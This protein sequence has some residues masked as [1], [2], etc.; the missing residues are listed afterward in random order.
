[1]KKISLVILFSFFAVISAFS[2][3]QMKANTGI[4]A[5]KMVDDQGTA[6]QYVN[7]LLHRQSDSTVIDAMATNDQGS[8]FFKDVNYGTYFLEFKFLGFK[9]KL[10]YDIS[11][12]KQ[13][14]FVRIGRV[15]LNADDQELSKVVVRGQASNVV[16]KIDKKIINVSKDIVA[17]GGDATDALRNVPSVNVGVN[18]DVTIRGSSNFTVMIN[19]KP[20]IL[21]PNE[22]LKSIPVENIDRIELITNPSAKYDP[23][24][25]A[26][27]INIITKNKKNDGFN[28]K[29]EIGTDNNLGYKGDIL[30][31]YK[32]NKINF[33]TEFNI[34]KRI[35]PMKYVSYRESFLPTDTFYMQ[36]NGENEWGHIG[37]E[38]KI[39]LNYYINDKTTLTL[40]GSYGVHGFIANSSS[41]QHAW[42]SDKSK[43]ENYFSS[44]ANNK[45]S[46]YTSNAEIDIE[47]KFNDKGHKIK[48]YAQYS[49]FTPVSN[50]ISIMDT[51]DAN[52]NSI[53]NTPFMQLTSQNRARTRARFQVDY[54]LPIGTKSKFQAGYTF[55][56]LEADGGY[57][58]ANFDYSTNNW[59]FDTTKYNDMTMYRQIHAAY[60]TFSSSLGKIFD[61]ELGFRTEYT[62]RLI[63]EDA[64]NTRYPIKRPDF[65]PTVHIS[66]SLPFDQQ[67]QL[68]YS[69][70]INRPRGWNLNPFPMYIDQYTIR[71][72]N[73]ALKPE[74]SNSYELNYLK[75]MGRNSISLETFYKTTEGKIDRI[76][77]IDG[78]AIVYT[79]ENLNKD[80]SLGSELSG[81]FIIFKMLML[82]ISS[83]AFNYRITGT[84]D[85]NPVDTSTF[86]W[87]SRINIMTMLPTGTGI[88]FGA[89]YKAPSVTLQ[90][91][92]SSMF[93]TFAG[94]RQSFFKRKLSL[95]IQA[96]DLF[97]TMRFAFTNSTKYLY[98]TNV[99]SSLHPTIGV[100]LTYRI[101]NYKS[102]RKR[103]QKGSSNSMDFMGEGDY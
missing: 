38:A 55:R 86:T 43:P 31:N 92:N 37:S 87:N 56:Y 42:W 25:D 88:Q 20:S 48:A 64:T 47:H 57:H 90:G 1:M 45:M 10:L 98:S 34:N 49:F 46:G 71:K 22:A 26:G 62:D 18:G 67:I 83:S 19:G 101:N 21:D 84:L 78:S 54:E 44:S 15:T 75:T 76:Q 5:G 52:W 79:T 96:W 2:Q 17:S 61:Y 58:V 6:L 91:R 72:G 53:S 32:K 28:G 8:F 7:V 103:G 82:N 74:Y 100:T 73:P 16:Y 77:Q 65:F 63:T 99:Y 35:R 9:S 93:I 12:S 66:K 60:V 69:R 41:Q 81:N 59:D 36:N 51:S 13:N 102:E 94:I 80:Y 14:R 29:I 40:S 89:F 3:P 95:S 50:N 85:G 23:D 4:I 27:I 70:R 24:G 30:L 68:S 97:N 11:V 33:F 39:G